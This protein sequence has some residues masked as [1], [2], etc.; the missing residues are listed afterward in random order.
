MTLT[1]IMVMKHSKWYLQ[2]SETLSMPISWLC[3]CL[4]SQF[5]SPMSPSPEM[6]NILTLTW[7]ATSLVTP[8]SI[9]FVYPRQFFQ[10]IQMP[11]G[12]FRIGPVVSEIRGGARNS[13]P[14]G[15]RYK[16]TPVGRGL[17]SI[18]CSN[19]YDSYRRICCVF[20]RDGYEREGGGG[21]SLPIRS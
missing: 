1:S 13:P 10:G 8:R 21:R 17:S 16:N 18:T 11:L 14:S 3:L 5:C 6:S 7:P 9:K 19:C 2:M 20:V 12:I 4:T 15:A